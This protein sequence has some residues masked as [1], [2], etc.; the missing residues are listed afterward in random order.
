MIIYLIVFAMM[1]LITYILYAIDKSKARNGKWRI[2]E[3]VLLFFSVAFGSLG[4]ILAMQLL[5][6]K[7]Q[8]W[9]FVF[10]NWGALML[11]IALGIYLY[12]QF[13]LSV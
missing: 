13:G 10:I 8:H 1:S 4:G 7:T 12:I 2:K 9:Y 5:R 3:S 11:H 6:H